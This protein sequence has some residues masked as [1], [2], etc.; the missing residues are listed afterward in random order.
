MGAR[1]LPENLFF[2][3]T[4]VKRYRNGLTLRPLI[5]GEHSIM[6]GRWVKHYGIVEYLRDPIFWRS[7]M[8]FNPEV[9]S[10]ADMF[11]KLW[12]EDFAGVDFGAGTYDEISYRD[13][14][15]FSERKV[16]ADEM[17]ELMYHRPSGVGDL[18]IAAAN[19][20]MTLPVQTRKM[21]ILIK[22]RIREMKAKS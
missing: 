16:G 17:V 12:A 10:S 1:S 22:E 18:Y 6:M 15:G 3:D 5:V 7:I 9:L 19:Q 20:Y 21:M 8:T 11:G 2:V 4:N 14:I 13:I